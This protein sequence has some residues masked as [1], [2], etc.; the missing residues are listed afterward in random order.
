M[1]LRRIPPDVTPNTVKQCLKSHLL[2]HFRSC[3]GRRTAFLRLS[4]ASWLTSSGAETALSRRGRAPDC[5]DSRGVQSDV[6]SWK[7]SVWDGRTSSAL[8][9]GWRERLRVIQPYR[10][11]RA[12]RGRSVRPSVRPSVRAAR[13]DS[14]SAGKVTFPVSLMWN[15]V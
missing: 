2:R 7:R 6:W 4:P 1:R 10:S 5:G 3:S 9:A 13:D 15:I 12:E 14:D 11:Q 8:V